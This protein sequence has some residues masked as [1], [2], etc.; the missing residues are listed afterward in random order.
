MKNTGRDILPILAL[1]MENQYV[2]PIA[3]NI[4]ESYESHGVHGTTDVIKKRIPGA[5]P[6]HKG[7]FVKK[8]FINYI[9]LNFL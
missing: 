6:G 9:H 7:Y 8:L 1:R 4:L 2:I 3:E 5:Q